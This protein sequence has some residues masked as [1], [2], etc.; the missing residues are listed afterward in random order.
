MSLI[1]TDS[2][3]YWRRLPGDMQIMQ[4]ATV[5]GKTYAIINNTDNTTA[6]Q[7]P[8]GFVVSTDGLRSWRAERPAH[9]ADRDPFFEFWL[10]ATANGLLAATYE[11]TL[12]RSGDGG[13]TWSRIP[14]PNQQTDLA[15]WLPQTG[16]WMFCGWVMANATCSADLGV[17]WQQKP[18]LSATTS[19]ASCGK[20]GAS[21]SDTQPCYPN[22]ITSDGSLLAWCLDGTLHRLAPNAQSWEQYRSAP[23][24]A[25]H[26][27]PTVIGDQIWLFGAA[28][29]TL[30]VATL[31]A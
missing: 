17:S 19:C 31:P 11:N 5:S 1:S 20:G 26:G 3:A 24:M 9:L 2:G 28:P 6:A 18:A 10:G 8:D 13:A 16:Q 22:A 7:Q 30:Y 23:G 15:A 25:I 29:G 12:W 21:Y 14:T 4:L 27:P